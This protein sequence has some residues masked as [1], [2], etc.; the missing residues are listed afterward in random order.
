VEELKETNLPT[1][2]IIPFY[3]GLTQET[4]FASLGRLAPQVESPAVG[5]AS[6]NGNRKSQ[7]AYSAFLESFYTLDANLRLL[8]TDNPIRSITITSASPADGK[9][10]IAAHLAWAAVAMGRKVL[11]IDTDLRRPQVHRWFNLPNLRGLSNG[12]TSDVDIHS[13]IQESP[14]DPNLSL[15]AAGPL[16]PSPG[17]LLS[18]NKMRSLI[19]QMTEEYDLVICDAPP[20]VFADAKLTAAHT[21][22]I[23]LVV[24]V[25]KTDRTHVL[26]SLEDLKGNAQCPVLGVVA[27][28]V[29]STESASSYYYQRYYEQRPE[30]KKN[31]LSPRKL[32]KRS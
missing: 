13:L 22:G 31:I 7:Q 6:W 26:K 11:L 21:D 1:L 25:G 20:V 12:I 2:G 17:R 29:K 24:G 30:K 5:E 3:G 27:N 28:G 19:Q 4:A 9:S 18:S 14:Q 16:P 15:L 23:L 8:G 10:S 32:Q